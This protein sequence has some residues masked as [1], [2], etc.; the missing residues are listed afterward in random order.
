[1]ANPITVLVVDNEP[2][3]AELAGEM[4]ER[5]HDPIVSVPATS[6]DEALEVFDNR[7]VD[8]IVS[9]YEMP[10]RNGIELLE[11]V[12]STDPELPFILFTGR[13][14]EDVA[15]EAIAA[16]VTQYLQKGLETNSTRCWRIRSRTLSRSIGP[17]SS[18]GRTSDGTSGRWR[19]STRR[20]GI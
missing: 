11:R 7:E 10:E 19:H 2:G 20:P 1:M 18:F 15:S 12:R 3:F 13:G 5:E 6:A 17:R 14:S 8:C 4:L 16:G 9:D